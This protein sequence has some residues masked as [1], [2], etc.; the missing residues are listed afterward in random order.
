MYQYATKNSELSR[1]FCT[2]EPLSSFQMD[3]FDLHYSSSEIDLKYMCLHGFNEPITNAL[4]LKM[5]VGVLK[6]IGLVYP[7]VKNVH[8][9]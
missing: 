2:N 1:S 5:G 7:P 4:H 8:L 6:K 3:Q 9:S